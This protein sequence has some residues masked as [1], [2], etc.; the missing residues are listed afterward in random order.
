[1]STMKRSSDKLITTK[2][3][4]SLI[5]KGKRVRAVYDWKKKKFISPEKAVD[6]K[7]PGRSDEWGFDALFWATSLDELFEIGLTSDCAVFLRWPDNME[8]CGLEE[9]SEIQ[10]YLK[11]HDY[12]VVIQ[13]LRGHDDSF[14]RRSEIYITTA[15]DFL[16]IIERAVNLAERLGFS[17]HSG[18]VTS[19]AILFGKQ[20]REDVFNEYWDIVHAESI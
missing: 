17:S 13:L 18:R 5:R 10:R 20:I 7:G 2:Q 19:T 1:M 9:S 11:K 6:G 12:D 3:L 4:S 8:R 15:Q 16:K 14:E